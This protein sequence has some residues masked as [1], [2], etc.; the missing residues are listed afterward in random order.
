MSEYAFETK[1]AITVDYV[2]YIDWL[3]KERFT[4]VVTG[5][6]T[7]PNTVVVHLADEPTKRQIAIIR[8][9]I[10]SES[11][12]LELSPDKE[13]ITANGTDVTTITIDSALLSGD[14]EISYKVTFTGTIDGADYKDGEIGSKRAPVTGRSVQL[15][16][17]AYFAGEY[18]IVVNRVG[19]NSPEFGTVT[20][21]AV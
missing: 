9:V 18:R 11:Y 1:Q 12:G 13:K 4:N 5:V 20:I 17:V 8:S 21:K 15:S 7:K 19:D 2:S 6:S 16:F 14:S 10:E 3:L